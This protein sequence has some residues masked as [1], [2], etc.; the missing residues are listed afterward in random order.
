MPHFSSLLS[1]IPDLCVPP[2]FFDST[3]GA[4]TGR[5]TINPTTTETITPIGPDGKN[6]GVTTE[7]SAFFLKGTTNSINIM[8]A[9]LGADIGC[10]WN[11]TRVSLIQRFPA[12]QK[13]GSYS[14]RK[15]TYSTLKILF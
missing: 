12:E 2:Y 11:L 7:S 1:L 3:G 5:L 15:D 9:T 14:L 4:D 6:T 8:S 10:R 13:A